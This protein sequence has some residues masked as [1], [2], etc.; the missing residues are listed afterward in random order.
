VSEQ[1]PWGVIRARSVE[2]ATPRR[3]WPKARTILVV[4]A[5]V[6]LQGAVTLFGL[7]GLIGPVEQ[8][9]AQQEACKNDAPTVEW[10]IKTYRA[11]TGSWPPAGPV[12]NTSVLV[13]P[14]HPGLPYLTIGPK[15]GK[16][17]INTDGRGGVLVAVP[18]AR[19]GGVNYEDA[20]NGNVPG[21][22]NPCNNIQ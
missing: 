9:E 5:V 1:N 15:S 7:A 4:L 14:G 16:Y 6:L 13:L 3:R 19:S 12:D 21:V 22:K 8:Q 17:A 18:P 2:A 10:A 20:I 11:V